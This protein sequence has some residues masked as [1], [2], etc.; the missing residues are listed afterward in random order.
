MASTF[1]RKLR[2]VQWTDVADYTL[3][4]PSF[5]RSPDSH[6]AVELEQRLKELAVSVARIVRRAPPFEPDWPVEAVP[7]L[8]TPEIGLG[9]L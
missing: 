4:V 1:P 5:W 9:K 3:T 8:E 6:R 7:I 2:T